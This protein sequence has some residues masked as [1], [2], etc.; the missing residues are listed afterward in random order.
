MRVIGKWVV[1][2]TGSVPCIGLCGPPGVGKTHFSRSL[3]EIM[4]LPFIQI[5]LG[6]QNDAEYLIG[7]GYTYTSSQPG[8]LIRKIC[9]NKS[10]RCI[11][12]FDELD[13]ISSKHNNYEISA[14]L[15]HLTDP[16][17]N[18]CFQ[19]RFFQ[20]IDFDLSNH[21]L[22]FSYNDA[23]KI[24]PILLDRITQ[25]DVDEYTKSEKLKLSKDFFNWFVTSS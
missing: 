17:S 6:G 14:I 16:E 7:H 21:L 9:E 10:N 3:S 5:N 23:R 25:I 11:I 13:K 19:D 12:Y 2:T 1:S 15:T 24:D 4:N 8:M 22:I 20:G 18:K